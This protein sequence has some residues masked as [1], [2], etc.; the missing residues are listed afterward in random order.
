MNV[1]SAE[2][3]LP[4]HSIKW[5][6]GELVPTLLNR[7]EFASLFLRDDGWLLAEAISGQK[8]L[9]APAAIVRVWL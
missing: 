1:H 3:M 4:P 7:V 2:V 6:R 9:V 8:F 5:G